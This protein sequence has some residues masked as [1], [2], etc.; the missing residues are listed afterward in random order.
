MAG[1]IPRDVA[2]AAFM[3]NMNPDM[4]LSGQPAGPAYQERL[5]NMGRAKV[6]QD[7]QEKQDLI[8]LINGAI[9]EPNPMPADSAPSSMAAKVAKTF[10]A[11]MARES[12][13]E[14]LNRM[15][16]IKDIIYGTNSL[17]HVNAGLRIATNL[18][19]YF[20]NKQ[21]RVEEWMLT[22]AP[23]QG[24][25]S[26]SN[27][28]VASL[29]GV[30]RKAVGNMSMFNK[31]YLEPYLAS[32]KAD[33]DRLGFASPLEFARAIGDYAVMRHMP[34]AN[35]YWLRNKLEEVQS[36]D[37]INQIL[38]IKAEVE[39]FLA[40]RDWTGQVD[41]DGKGITCAG[42]TD[43]YAKEWIR[44]FH[45]Q[46]D[47]SPETM[48]QYAQRISDMHTEV[49]KWNIEQGNVD[50][51]TVNA[52][53]KNNF[54]SYVMLRS[55]HDAVGSLPTDSTILNA[56][57]FHA[58]DG[59]SSKVP[60]VNAFDSLHAHMQRVSMDN[61]SRELGMTLY[62]MEARAE[63]EGRESPVR[64][65]DYKTVAARSQAGGSLGTKY[66][67]I[68]EGKD[69]FMLTYMHPELREDGSIQNVRKV[70]TFDNAYSDERGITGA[71]LNESMR[72]V[73][74]NLFTRLASPVTGFLGG[75]NTH[76]NV[77]F[78]P[79]N[80][81][82]DFGERLNNL[83]GQTYTLEN[84][85]KVNGESFAFSFAAALPKVMG[86][87]P[88][89]IRGNA[90]T[91]ASEMGRYWREYIQQGVKQEYDPTWHK[92]GQDA[93]TVLAQL[94]KD[95]K[96]DSVLRM[97]KDFDDA[98]RKR[99]INGIH[100]YNDYFNNI[101]A[102]AQYYA[103]RKNHVTIDSAATGTLEVV[104]LRESGVTSAALRSIY[105]FAKPTMQG[106]ASMLRS[107]GL[108]PNA[109]GQFRPTAK[110]MALLFG[111]AAAIST[112]WSLAKSMLGEDAM[113]N[114]SIESA[115]RAI[116]FVFDKEG[117]SINLPIPFGISPI[118]A[119]LGIGLDRVMRNKMEPLDFVGATIKS[120]FKAT[121]P[122]N[123]Q[124]YA[125]SDGALSYFMALAS[126]TALEPAVQVALNKGYYGQP[127]T[128]G[129]PASTTPM[130]MQGKTT[131]PSGWSTFAKML[132]DYSGGIIN[133]APEQVKTFVEGY[134]GGITRA[135]P[136][137]I[138]RNSLVALGFDETTQGQL[139][140][141]MSMLGASIVY[142]KIPTTHTAQFYNELNKL[143]KEIRKLGVKLSEKGA[144]NTPEERA[145]VWRSKLEE[146][147]MDSAKIDN[148]LALYQATKDKAKLSAELRK[149]TTDN[150]DLPDMSDSELK[151][152][153]EDYV[154]QCEELYITALSTRQ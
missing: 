142:K 113:D 98:T 8:D 71:A 11:Q 49:N 109:A 10:S 115:S 79:V 139:G 148:Y 147:G 102:F 100:I 144:Y 40:Y 127:L 104:N 119:T 89:V 51:E 128:Y 9:S 125:M 60:I 48:A 37:D 31:Q 12:T 62:N 28:A 18:S 112:L 135:I 146:A 99:I 32:I 5:D 96:M 101:A 122:A 13:A 56:G 24:R 59:M 90:D 94:R 136:D 27:T 130:H 154:D 29:R 19:Y 114:I 43:G 53:N 149:Q 106:A 134:A 129:D 108:S 141:T 47:I 23:M 61:A 4:V 105:A 132:F 55:A 63:A 1:C 69:G 68:L 76:Y 145:S 92:E 77:L 93:S 6:A 124:G 58:R 84:G 64:I 41:E 91:N 117:H 138:S 57:N 22:E 87:L 82:R 26:G 151:Q 42:R 7:V 140:F 3:N 143:T 54:K 67:G 34:E 52:L 44:L 116:P 35:E 25:D 133:A 88:K 107:V 50:E 152:I 30:E 36:S 74:Q 118:A 65:E 20:K 16:Q 111:Q 137:A 46:Y 70:V 81:V 66:R 45:E 126:P 80:A 123:F 73:Q 33:A 103:L 78:S 21:A 83:F 39:R 14:S 38:K 17:G 131:T 86:F 153:F 72:A 2:V 150:P 121:T 110:G 97:L 120:L 95:K 15:E 75:L 85:A